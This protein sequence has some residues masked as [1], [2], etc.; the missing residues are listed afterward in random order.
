MLYMGKLMP[1]VLFQISRV[2]RVTS[3]NG[4]AVS[5]LLPDINLLCA[6]TVIPES[7]SVVDA[8][9]PGYN[10]RVQTLKTRESDWSIFLWL[11]GFQGADGAVRELSAGC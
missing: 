10:H 6:E 4:G 11:F 9:V 1:G 3:A 5:L 8:E 2:H 7:P